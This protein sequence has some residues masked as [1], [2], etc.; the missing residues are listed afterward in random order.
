[1][2]LD[3]GDEVI[4]ANNGKLILA[5]SGTYCD[6]DG[7]PTGGNIDNREEFVY[8]TKTGS[9]YHTSNECPSLKARSPEL[10]KMSLLDAK[11]R[12]YKSCKRC[13]KK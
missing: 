10:F 12:G 11:K 8:V 5:N 4:E 1:M 9:V 2:Y 7:N 13:K 3:N 6:E